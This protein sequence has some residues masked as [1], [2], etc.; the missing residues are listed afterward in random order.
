MLKAV[1]FDFDGVLLE[2]VDVKTRAFRQLFSKEN[3]ADLEKIVNYHLKNGGVSRFEKFRHIYKDILKRPLSEQEFEVLCGQFAALVVDEVVASPWV[4]GAKEF[5][6]RN[7]GRYQFF[8]ASGTPEDEINR[9]VERVGIRAFFK[10]VLGSPRKKA[11]LL[12]AL[13]EKHRL[14]NTEC[15][16]VGDAENDWRAAQELKIPFVWRRAGTRQAL[17]DFSGPVLESLKNLDDCLALLKPAPALWVTRPAALR[18]VL[19]DP[20]AESLDWCYIGSDLKI[21]KSCAALLDPSLQTD[22]GNELDIAGNSLKQPFLDWIVRMGKLQKDKLNWW[23]SRL[24]SK[25]PLQTD[26]FELVCCLK[27]V[28]LWAS[29]GKPAR[30]VI[31]ENPWLYETLRQRFWEESAFQ[32]TGSAAWQVLLQKIG[33]RLRAPLARTRLSVRY[34]ALILAGRRFP[35]RPILSAQKPAVLIHSW[36]EDRCFL[37]EGRFED[38]YTGRLDEILAQ[39]GETV[40]RLTP[41]FFDL[42]HARRLAPLAKDFI[43]APAYIDM[44]EALSSLFGR[45]TI[46][47]ADQVG[48]LEGWDLRSLLQREQLRENGESG[49]S[50]YRLWYQ[51]TRRIIRAHPGAFKCVIYPFENQPWEKCLCL[52]WKKEAPGARLIGYQHSSFGSLLLNYFLGKGEDSESPLPDR[53]IANGKLGVEALKKAG[54]P[55]ASLANG[56]ALRYEYLQRLREG[57]ASKEKPSSARPRILVGLS[58]SRAPCASL[59]ENLLATFRESDGLDFLV[60]TH[61]DLPLNRIFERPPEMPRWLHRPEKPLRALF[62]EADLFL[63]TPPTTTYWE[64]YLAGLPVLKYR[65]DFLDID[66]IETLKDRVPV[67][68]RSDIREVLLKTLREKKAP[69]LEELRELLDFVFSPVDETAWTEA[70]NA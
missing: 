2:S 52:A 16:F 48:P 17:P 19:K 60:K 55:A 35:A 6:E 43:F 58:T 23:C 4:P 42:L 27:L 32:F 3:P 54:H 65:S 15:I 9:I 25:S 28:K 33:W 13:L 62:E 24:A 46:A 34:A 44:G 64:A 22:F 5:L 29:A 41:P 30:L 45:F 38:P 57:W 39:A 51:T 67:C 53:I 14:R 1:I 49:F 47:G 18:R 11:V 37:K 36:I 8:I 70:V 31:V 10:E 12:K 61:P 68:S 50:G 56:G 59:L 40:V 20:A 7:A 26:F 21:K 66:I 69:P 63:F